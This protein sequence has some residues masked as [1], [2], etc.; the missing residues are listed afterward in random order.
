M[1]NKSLTTERVLTLL[2]ATP[3]RIA[4]LTADLT[5]EELQTRPTPDE[6]SA[7]EVLAHLRAC[8]DVWGNYIGSTTSGIAVSGS[9]GTTGAA[10]GIGTS[11]TGL[12]SPNGNDG[13]LADAIHAFPT[14]SRV[15]GGVMVEAA[16]QLG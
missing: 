8:A 16:K 3:Q 2:A 1:P 13:F 6:W 12:Q 5:P 15:F 14:A 9:N 4:A 11:G 10:L 7:N